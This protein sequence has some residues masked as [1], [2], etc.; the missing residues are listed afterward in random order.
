[1][2]P[3]SLTL[4]PVVVVVVFVDDFGWVMPLDGNRWC[5]V[6]TKTRWARVVILDQT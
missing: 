1:M 2:A 3:L 5:R 4:S 6:Q